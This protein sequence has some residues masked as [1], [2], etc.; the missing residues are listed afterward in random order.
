VEEGKKV[1]A[2]VSETNEGWNA[3]LETIYNHI[4]NRRVFKYLEASY[5]S[6][7]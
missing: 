6:I 5:F 4:A 7:K 1:I 2:Q 3:Y